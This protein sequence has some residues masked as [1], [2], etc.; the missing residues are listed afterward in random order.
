M[1]L[2]VTELGHLQIED[3]AG[4]QRELPPTEVEL[5]REID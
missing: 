1:F 3:D 4:E 2:G 5:L